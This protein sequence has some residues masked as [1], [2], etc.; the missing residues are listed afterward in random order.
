MLGLICLN[1]LVKLNVLLGRHLEDIYDVCWSPDERALISGSVDHSIII[2][3][4]DLI[5]QPT[6]KTLILR[7]HKHYVQGVAWDPLGFYVASLSSDRAC[8][9]YRAGTKNCLAHVSKAGKQRL[10]Q[11]DSWKSFFRR[12]TFSPDGLL[13]VCPSGNLEDATFAGLTNSTIISSTNGFEQSDKIVDTAIPLV[14]PQ[15]AAHIFVRSNFTRPVVSLPTGSK[16]VVAVRFCP[17]PFQLRQVNLNC[18]NA[19]NQCTSL[20]NL[21]YRWLFCLVLED[22]VLFYDTQQTVP[23]AQ[24]SQL[25]YQALNDASW[26]KDGHLVVICSTDGYCSLIHFAHGELGA[27]YRGTFGAPNPQ[28]ISIENAV[29][30]T[31]KCQSND[32]EMLSSVVGDADSD[33]IKETNNPSK[34]NISSTTVPDSNKPTTEEKLSESSVNNNPTVVDG[35]STVSKQKRRVQLTTLVSFSD[36][37]ITGN[38]RTDNSQ[39]SKKLPNDSDFRPTNLKA[40]KFEEKDIIEIKTWRQVIQN[41]K[42]LR[43]QSNTMSTFCPIIRATAFTGVLH[44]YQVSSSLTTINTKAVFVSTAIPSKKL[45]SRAVWKQALMSVEQM[46]GSYELFVCQSITASKYL[47]KQHRKLGLT[48]LSSNRSIC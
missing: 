36:G 40:N 26:S 37:N 29:S 1:S 4:L 43:L 25:H 24:V 28:P 18:Q 10:F 35:A 2:W 17:Q 41:F 14:A 42:R 9:I 19:T 31:D 7:D 6:I 12:L 20:F 15:H 44:V 47:S 48:N 30:E 46:K 32:V 39:I 38:S 16:P 27:F 45:Y 5:P 22:S 13:L 11:D 23:F 34:S 33:P 21:A 3:H 8:R